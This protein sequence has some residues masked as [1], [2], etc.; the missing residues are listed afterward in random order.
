MP[1]SDRDHGHYHDN[2]QKIQHI[3]FRAVLHSRNVFVDKLINRAALILVIWKLSTQW[4]AST[5]HSLAA[6]TLQF[7]ENWSPDVGRDRKQNCLPGAPSHSHATAT[8]LR[9]QIPPTATQGLLT[10]YDHITSHHIT[11]YHRISSHTP[12]TPALVFRLKITVCCGGSSDWYGEK[13]CWGKGWNNGHNCSAAKRPKQG[14]KQ[15]RL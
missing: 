10:S 1:N 5:G 2:D 13:A 11:E 7:L 3:D 9:Y 12:M 15:P 8:L 14:G 6:S 4:V